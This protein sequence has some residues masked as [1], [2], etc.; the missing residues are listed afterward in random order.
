MTSK[1]GTEDRRVIFLLAQAH[2]RVFAELDRVLRETAGV[3]TTQ[4]GALLLLQAQDGCALGALSA[5]LSLDNS[6]ITTLVDRL[7]QRELVR[8]AP[9]TDDRRVVSVWLTP[10]GRRAAR[11]ALPRIHAANAALLGPYSAR[12]QQ[13]FLRVLRDLA[14]APAVAMEAA[15]G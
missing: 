1:V 8:R 5:G 7:A 9:G 3:T 2:K 11:Q 6:A 4:A 10:A 14:A 12:E 15:Q 13:A